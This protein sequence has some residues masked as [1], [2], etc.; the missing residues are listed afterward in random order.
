M[1]TNVDERIILIS[2]DEKRRTQNVKKHARWISVLLHDNLAH[3]AKFLSKKFVVNFQQ[4]TETKRTVEL[5]TGTFVF[6]TL[7]TEFAYD[8]IF[9]AQSYIGKETFGNGTIREGKLIL[10]FKKV[11]WSRHYLILI[12]GTGTEGL[13]S[14]GTVNQCSKHVYSLAY[15]M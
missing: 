6:E 8:E 10:L 12:S 3:F 5:D 13:F 11:K 9:Q 7:V 1:Y 4:P 2:I 15:R 14:Y